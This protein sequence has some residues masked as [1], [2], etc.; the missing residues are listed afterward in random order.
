METKLE[1][2]CW[3]SVWYSDYVWQKIDENIFFYCQCQPTTLCYIFGQQ[4]SVFQNKDSMPNPHKATIILHKQS[5]DKYN[6]YIYYVECQ[7]KNNISY[8]IRYKI[9]ALSYITVLTVVW[10]ISSDLCI[11]FLGSKH[12]NIKTSYPTWSTHTYY[13]FV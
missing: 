2:F 12:P 8:K 7:W 3:V 5:C 13:F 9:S 4:P 10:K 6:F 1:K 11:T